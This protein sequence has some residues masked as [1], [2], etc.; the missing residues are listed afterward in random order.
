MISKKHKK[1]CKAFHY[2]E[3][4]LILASMV[5]G[6]VSISALASLFGVPL[7]IASFAATITVCVTT[8]G[9]KK[10]K[11]IIQKKSKEESL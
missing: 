5:T 6:C 1:V 8:G 9:I 10:Y 4:S 2:V 11:S 3:H 7:G